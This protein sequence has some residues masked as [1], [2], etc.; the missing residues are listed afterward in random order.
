MHVAVSRC[1]CFVVLHP[2]CDAFSVNPSHKT[3]NYAVKVTGDISGTKAQY[4]GTKARRRASKRL[5]SGLSSSAGSK[6]RMDATMKLKL[7]V[8]LKC[9]SSDIRRSKRHGVLEWILKRFFI[10]PWRCMSCHNRF[11]R[12]RFGMILF[13]RREIPKLRRLWVTF[14]T[15]LRSLSLLAILCFA[16]VYRFPL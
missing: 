4:S 9:G 8:C 1:G 15:A 12:P 3:W 10:L 13:T 16:V 6:V 2:S 7:L 11:F 5:R 14:R